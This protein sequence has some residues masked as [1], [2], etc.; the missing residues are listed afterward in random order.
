MA[1]SEYLRDIAITH[2]KNGKTTAEIAVLLANQIH[3]TTVLRW[4]RQY[5][6]TGSF[7]AGK[8]TARRRSG[9]TK[10]LINL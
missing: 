2:Y 6:R 1:K 3:R 5:K 7:S 9:R 8:S 4:I 10:P